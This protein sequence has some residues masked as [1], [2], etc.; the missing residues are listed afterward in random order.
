VQVEKKFCQSKKDYRQKKG[1]YF[2]HISQKGI[3]I[4]RGYSVQ[5]FVVSGGR[6]FLGVACSEVKARM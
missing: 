2:F 3:I 5:I 6:D 4:V 1:K